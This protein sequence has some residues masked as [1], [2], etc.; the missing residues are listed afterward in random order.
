M[1]RW[2]T[3]SLNPP[4]EHFARRP[5]EPAVARWDGGPDGPLLSREA[6]RTAPDLEN[7]SVR[8]LPTTNEAA[9]ET[10][11]DAGTA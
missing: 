9:A 1:R 3:P 10:G 2:S 8:F 4:A 7:A 11:R 6:A 5:A